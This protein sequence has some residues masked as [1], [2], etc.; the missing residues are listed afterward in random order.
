MYRLKHKRTS[1][2]YTSYFLHY[3][4]KHSFPKMIQSNSVYKHLTIL[5]STYD[6]I[7][8]F[9]PTPTRKSR[10]QNHSIQ[11]NIYKFKDRSSESNSTSGKRNVSSSS[12]EQFSYTAHCSKSFGAARIVP[13]SSVFEEHETNLM[14]CA[15]AQMMKVCFSD[16]IFSFT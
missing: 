8:R 12:L 11:V 2:S 6:K 16:Y 1:L 13:K 3:S 4:I 5:L 15:P 9:L 7:Y 10:L 14:P